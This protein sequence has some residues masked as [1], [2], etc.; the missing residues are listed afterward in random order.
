MTTSKGEVVK[1]DAKLME[2]QKTW[3]TKRVDW[4]LGRV[5]ALKQILDSS[6]VEMMELLSEVAT[7]AYYTKLGYGDFEEYCES[8]LGFKQRKG[9]YLIS[10]FRNLVS[11]AGVSRDK[12]KE[13]EWSVAKEIATLPKEELSGG[14]AEKWLERAKGMNRQELTLAVRKAK[15]KHKEEDEKKHSEEIFYKDE[16]LLDAS[17][18]ANVN[19]AIQNARKIAAS[20]NKPLG[21]ITK[22]F[23]LDLIALEFNASHAESSNVKL[24]WILDQ[25][26]R[27]W[28]VECVAIEVRN[29]KEVVV[30]GKS[31]MKKY[32]MEFEDDEE[33]KKK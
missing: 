31:V 14:K 20:M 21:K 27:V 1:K 29:G 28:G 12:L 11:E 3:D 4:V 19:L 6:Y 23:L 17:Q 15:N 26:D 18:R 10:I 22:G 30:H 2:V 24:R 25:V 5:D 16:V 33:E 9:W 32:G 7:K 13:V 8:V